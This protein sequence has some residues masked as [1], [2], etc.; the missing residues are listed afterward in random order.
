M[1]RAR[2][3]KRRPY[4][5]V[6]P[7]VIAAVVLAGVI[8]IAQGWFA[9]TDTTSPE[10]SPR[11]LATEQTAT[12]GVPPTPSSSPPS[13][14]SAPATTPP[15][16][17]T[18]PQTPS[19]RTP[20][21]RAAANAEGALNACRNRVHAADTALKAAGVGVSHW[22]QHVQA[23][24]DANSAKISVDEMDAIFKRTR[25]AGAADVS[26][27]QGAVRAY[28]AKSGSCEA[29]EGASLDVNL[30]LA[31]CA[32]RHKAQLPVLRAAQDAMSDWESHLAAMARSRMGKVHDAQGVWLK[33]WR[34][35]PPHI[36]AYQKAERG[37]SPA[38]C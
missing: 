6:L 11:V 37:Y 18:G 22:S 38:E 21:K 7:V 34:A 28:H 10:A 16:T 33:A 31:G 3:A 24:T 17:T 36:K 12:P 2:R 4:R 8:A 27:Y 15:A 35:A 13:S 19:G 25:L 1:A 14:S 5:V 30:Q 29:V 26:S 23:Q 20:A 32:S 9:G